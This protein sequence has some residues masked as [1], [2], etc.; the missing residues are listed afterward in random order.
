MDIESGD[1]GRRA[2]RARAAK[3]LPAEHRAAM[4]SRTPPPSRRERNRSRS[5]VRSA[6]SALDRDITSQCSSVDN[7]S[8]SDED[9]DEHNESDD[10]VIDNGDIILGNRLRSLSICS[11]SHL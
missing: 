9:S 5:P 2:P 10:A 7:L 4:G 11:S 3:R 8:S 1:L 6:S